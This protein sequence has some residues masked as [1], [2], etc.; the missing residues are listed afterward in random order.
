MQPLPKA[1]LQK[2][3][4][5]RIFLGIQLPLSEEQQGMSLYRIAGLKFR[6]KIDSSYLEIITLLRFHY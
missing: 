1:G 6:S 2:L 3:E 4:Y 5:V